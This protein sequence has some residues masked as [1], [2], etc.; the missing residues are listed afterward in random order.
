M[1]R[2]SLASFLA[3]A[4]LPLFSFAAD[5]GRDAQWAKDFRTWRSLK[6]RRRPTA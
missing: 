5:S 2:L 4:G 6:A 3:L 1:R